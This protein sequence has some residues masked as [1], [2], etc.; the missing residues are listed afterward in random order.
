[1]TEAQYSATVDVPLAAAYKQW[2]DFESFP[3]FL[4]AVTNVETTSETY[5]HWTLSVGRLTREFDAEILEQLP[6]QRVAWRTI[7]GDISFSGRAEF[8]A[9]DG[10]STRVTLTVVWQPSTATERAAAA[11]GADDRTVRMAL[12]SF[13]QHTEA[14]G[15]PPGRSHV[16]LASIDRDESPGP[17]V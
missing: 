13:K 1:M 8:E 11:L 7:G 6:E 5:S 4:D 16:M 2:I 14:T 12:R 3:Q 15:G 9:V 17:P 10:D